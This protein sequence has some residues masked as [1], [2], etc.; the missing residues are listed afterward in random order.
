[1]DDDPLVGKNIRLRDLRFYNPDEMETLRAWRNQWDVRRTTREYRLITQPRHASWVATRADDD[2][3]MMFGIEPLYKRKSVSPYVST[4][5][6]VGVCGLTYIDWKNRNAEV[7]IY[8]GRED[9]RRKGYAKDALEC[10]CRYAFLELGLHMLYAEIFAFNK[11]SSTLFERAGFEYNGY[12]PD[13][14]YRFGK[15]HHGWFYALTKDEWRSI[16]RG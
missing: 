8:I 14:I 12:I 7:S 1:M 10:L 3:T 4:M 11:S 5:A 6:L 13:R 2:R 16:A 9:A 15:W